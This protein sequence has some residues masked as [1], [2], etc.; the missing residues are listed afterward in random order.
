LTLTKNNT[1]LTL[2]TLQGEVLSWTTCKNCGF[3]GGE[4]ST[5]IATITTAE[6]MGLRALDFKIKKVHLVFRGGGRFQ[7]AALRGLIRSKIQVATLVVKTLV[8]YNGCRIKK[9]RRI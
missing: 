4:K 8:P 9:S 1:I 6:E 2:T 7:R 3:Q 5:E